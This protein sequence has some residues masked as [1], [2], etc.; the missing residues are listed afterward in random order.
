MSVPPDFVIVGAPKCGTTS[1][2]QALRRHPRIYF[3]KFLKEPHYFAVDFPNRR[4]VTTARDYDVLFDGAETWQIRGEASVLYLKSEQAIDAILK[5]R[6]GC[7]IVAMVRDPIE[8]FVSWHNENLLSLDEDEPDPIKAWRLQA[9]R[10][11]G[12]RVPKLC[13]EPAFLQYREICSL[14]HQIQ[15]LFSKVPAGQRLVLTLDDLILAPSETYARVTRFLGVENPGYLRFE[16]ANSFRQHRIRFPARIGRYMLVHSW[17]RRM[18]LRV[19][20]LLNSW[21]IH[22]LAWMNAANTRR[23]AKPT[24]SAEDRLELHTAFDEEI[25]ILENLLERDLSN[26]KLSSQAKYYGLRAI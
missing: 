14:G 3:P 9:E 20:P 17:A 18:R 22:P 12:R 4:E 26:W 19:K 25:S 7:K 10:A 21:G 23:V 13:K 1:L 5:R 2:Y 8:M 11:S 24:L 16:Q 6:A 15:R